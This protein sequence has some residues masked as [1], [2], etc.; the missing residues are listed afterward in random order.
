MLSGLGLS[1]INE[2]FELV[3]G[4]R[5]SGRRIKSGNDLLQFALETV[6]DAALQRKTAHHINKIQC[7]LTRTRFFLK[8]Q[9]LYRGKHRE[10]SGGSGSAKRIEGAAHD[11]NSE[12]IAV[13]GH[14]GSSTPG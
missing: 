3:T 4:V 13:R 8:Q 7:Q 14:R 5:G 6:R 10:P 9:R 12:T 1:M 2:C 11:S